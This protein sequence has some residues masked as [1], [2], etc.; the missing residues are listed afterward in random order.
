MWS[1]QFPWPETG[2]SARP[3]REIKEPIST[4]PVIK[5]RGIMAKVCHM[6]AAILPSPTRRRPGLFGPDG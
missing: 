4:E 1:G 6:I 3:N 5:Q 2:N